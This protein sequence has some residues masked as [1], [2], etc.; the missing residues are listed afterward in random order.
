MGIIYGK[1]QKTSLK[2]YGQTS[3]WNEISIRALWCWTIQGVLEALQPAHQ[4]SSP[5]IE[6]L[7]PGSDQG[8]GSA[9]DGKTGEVLAGPTLQWSESM[10]RQRSVEVAQ[11]QG[12]LWR[13][14]HRRSCGSRM[15]LEQSRA[16][17]GRDRK[18]PWV[19]GVWS[20]Q[21]SERWN[22][23]ICHPRG[24]PTVKSI[25]AGLAFGHTCLL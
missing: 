13:S 10:Q 15:C 3:R 5:E 6:G 9:N 4:H 16:L 2:Q 24:R 20:K 21:T 14:E 22:S 8:D 19:G 25:N 11:H 1:P 18:L 23:K 12:A 17:S 7:A